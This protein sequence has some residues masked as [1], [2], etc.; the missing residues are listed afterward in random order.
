MGPYGQIENRGIIV[1]HER[2]SPAFRWL[3][4]S[5][6]LRPAERRFGC[7][8]ASSS[9]LRHPYAARRCADRTAALCLGYPI[10]TIE[11]FEM[12]PSVL[13]PI[14]LLIGPVPPLVR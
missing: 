13:T 9:W 12:A 3:C 10:E 8:V 7:Y 1:A 4:S 6:P 11:Q 5:Q 2:M 14:V